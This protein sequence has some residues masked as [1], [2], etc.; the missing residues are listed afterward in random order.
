MKQK[1]GVKLLN[2]ITF[3]DLFLWD[4]KRF[5]AQKI[6]S[7]YP[8]V[9]LGD[10][11]TEEN[12]KVKLTDYPDSEF[13]ILGVNNKTG[14]FD[15]YT[16]K[17]S[18]TKQAYK[19]METGWIAYNPYRI[20]VGSIGIR[21]KDLKNDYISPAYVVFSCSDALIPEYLYLLLRSHVYNK[22]IKDNTTGAVRQSLSYDKLKIIDIPLPSINNQRIILHNYQNK[23]KNAQALINSITQI[24]DSFKQYLN[25]ELGIK[26]SNDNTKQLGLGFINYSDIDKW[27]LNFLKS[28]SLLSTK[29]KSCKL[30]E[31]CSIGSGG[32]P[33]R[34]RKDYYQGNIPWVKTG[35]V[36]NDI[37]YETEEK[38]SVSA[39]NESSAKIYPKGSIIIALYGQGATRGRTAKLG[40]DAA[41]NQAC[42]VLHNF[43]QDIV[44]N[45]YIWIYLINEYEKLRSMASGNNQPNLNLGMISNYLIQ[46]PPISVQKEIIERFNSKAETIKK[47]HHNIEIYFDEA[48][49]EFEKAV[50]NNE[51]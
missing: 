46:I 33:K 31:L 21:T 41:T 43:K 26:L 6:K 23:V 44:L 32:T 37:I 29:Y 8:I 34:S 3:K 13:G 1:S 7:Q 24:D 51:D 19:K 35:E 45:N 2:H 5:S 38:I 47:I 36:L 49:K 15:A 27:G 9:K 10:Y 22:I 16:V 17:G 18:E 11:I 48:I 25:K 14:I 39:I 30:L 50:L 12:H 4:V 40:I 42:A 20:N 28:K